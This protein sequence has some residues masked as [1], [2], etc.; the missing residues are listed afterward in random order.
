[1]TLNKEPNVTL[2]RLKEVLDY[3]PETGVFVWKEKLNRRGSD[4]TRGNKGAIAGRKSNG[5]IYI[6]INK[7]AYLAQRLAWFYMIGEWPKWILRFKDEDRSNIRFT[8]LYA[9]EQ[10]EFT[11]LPKA[12]YERAWRQKF[13]DRVKDKYL[14]RDFGMTLS[15]YVHKYG[16]QNGLCATCQKPEF[17]ERNGK[18]K[19]LAVDHDHKTGEIRDLLCASCNKV[20]GV[21]DDNI[22]LLESMIRYLKKHKADKVNLKDALRA[23]GE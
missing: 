5:Y 20:L 6:G 14:R 7:K 23:V 16:A 12:E 3:N 4:G 11:G 8:N 18:V 10:H 2:E 17:E 21:V 22:Q 9:A 19:A 1:M 15:E 13:P